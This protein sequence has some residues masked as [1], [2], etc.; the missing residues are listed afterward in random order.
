MGRKD[1]RAKVSL[2]LGKCQTQKKII[3]LSVCLFVICIGP[4][5]IPIWGILPFLALVW[6]Y[7]KKW[8]GLVPNMPVIEP[9]PVERS[10]E[11]KSILS[12]SPMSTEKEETVGAT[13][14]SNSDIYGRGI[15]NI[16]IS[17]L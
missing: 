1:L 5:C 17:S 7:V 12:T 6:N 14:N 13:V 3:M 16:N 11:E 15:G 9:K 8:M 4:V 2:K 10:S